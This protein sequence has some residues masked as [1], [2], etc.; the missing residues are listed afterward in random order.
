[1]TISDVFFFNFYDIAVKKKFASASR[2]ETRVHR[3]VE[4]PEYICKY[5][6]AARKKIS[7]KFQ[8]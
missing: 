1:M 7:K 6:A 4:A 2:N 3:K 5:V 8:T